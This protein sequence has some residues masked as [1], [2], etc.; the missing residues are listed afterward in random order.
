M[1]KRY[2]TIAEIPI[3]ARDYVKMLVDEG[4]LAGSGQ[5]LDI[6]DDMIRTWLVIEAHLRKIGV[7]RNA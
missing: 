4:S 3:Y 7:I 5:G 1:A 6:T 2:N